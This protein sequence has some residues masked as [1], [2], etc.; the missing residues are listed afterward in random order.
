L[1][2]LGAEKGKSGWSTEEILGFKNEKRY[3]P[4]GGRSARRFS[5]L[6]RRFAVDP[7]AADRT[8]R[9]IQRRERRSRNWC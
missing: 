3:V 7:P 5:L 9:K 2:L 1:V 4:N 8:K 6:C